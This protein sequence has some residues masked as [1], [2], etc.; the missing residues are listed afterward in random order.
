[1]KPQFNLGLFVRGKGGNHKIESVTIKLGSTKGRGSSTRMFN[2]CNQRSANP[3]LCINQ[4]ITLIPSIPSAP[5]ITTVTSSGTDL[6][7][8]FTP[9]TNNGGS[10]ITG[11]EYTYTN[12]EGNDPTSVTIPSTSTTFTI[13]NGVD[14]IKNIQLR[15]INAVGPS[16]WSNTMTIPRQSVVT[17]II[18]GNSELTVNFTQSGDGGTPITNYYYAI[19][20]NR[21]QK[22]PMTPAPTVVSPGVYSYI[23]NGLSPGT[24]YSVEVGVSNVIGIDWSLPNPPLSGTTN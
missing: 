22:Q 2:Y 14:T 15:A 23:I 18:S 16:P 21:S 1:M 17:S 11:Y 4:F 12:S 7:F 24:S 3:S 10:V 5:T 8:S 9:P 13:T 6:I 20:G 19:D